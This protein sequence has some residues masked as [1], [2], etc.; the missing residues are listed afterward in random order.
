MRA[1]IMLSAAPCAG[2]RCVSPFCAEE[3]RTD[4][5]FTFRGS[6]GRQ[7]ETANTPRGQR[8]FK[9]L[10][11]FYCQ[12]CPRLTTEPPFAFPKFTITGSLIP[13]A[14][15]AV[16]PVAAEFSGHAGLWDSCT[17]DLRGL[18]QAGI[19]NRN[20]VS[21]RQFAR[22]TGSAVKIFWLKSPNYPK[23][24]Q[25]TG[26]RNLPKARWHAQTTASHPK[27]RLHHSAAQ[28]ATRSGQDLACTAGRSGLRKRHF[29]RASSIHA[30]DRQGAGQNL[31]DV[32][33]LDHENITFGDLSHSN[34]LINLSGLGSGFTVLLDFV[35]AKPRPQG[36]SATCAW[37]LPR[38]ARRHGSNLIAYQPQFRSGA[39]KKFSTVNG[40]VWVAPWMAIASGLMARDGDWTVRQHPPTLMQQQVISPKRRVCWGFFFLE[41]AGWAVS[42]RGTF[43]AA[44]RG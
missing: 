6:P 17:E 10:M 42:G 2:D 40:I 9:A 12:I 8:H 23:E 18:R 32:P 15:Y 30:A 16:Q 19:P 4:W 14:R 27:T 33:S 21:C 34:S 31:A 35:V 36:T 22:T 43:D 20:P 13:M 37:K 28:K 26:G 5:R 29:S 39:R 1:L 24:T 7:L 44:G 25:R 3:T 11:D 41:K 38:Q